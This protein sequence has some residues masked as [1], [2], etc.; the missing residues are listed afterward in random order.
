MFPPALAAPPFPGAGAWTTD[1]KAKSRGRRGLRQPPLNSKSN[2]RPRGA[3]GPEP[4]TNEH[5]KGAH[6]SKTKAQQP[7]DVNN[8]DHINTGV[9]YLAHGGVGAIGG[10]GVT[11]YLAYGGAGA[12]GM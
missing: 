1:V 11:V 12:N 5:P 10:Y 7:V 3:C 8:S 2:A 9:L 4:T 6:K